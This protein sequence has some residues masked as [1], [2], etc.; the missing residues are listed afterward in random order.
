M[1][2]ENTNTEEVKTESTP[3]E[4]VSSTETAEPQDSYTDMASSSSDKD[5]TQDN[6]FLRTNFYDNRYTT[7][8][9]TTDYLS[10]DQKDK[11]I[12]SPTSLANLSIKADGNI[13]A[14]AGEYSSQKIGAAGSQTEIGIH[15]R[16]V[17]NR[18]E[19]DT[20]EIV[21]NKHKMNPYLYELTDFKKITNPISGIVGDLCIEG[22]VLVKAWDN[23]LKKYV[24]I[25]RRIRTP[26]FFPRLDVPSIPSALDIKDLTSLNTSG[27]NVNGKTLTLDEY[28]AS[29]VGSKNLV[30]TN[31][32]KTEEAKNN[33]VV[34][35]L[36]DQAT[37][38]VEGVV[39]KKNETSK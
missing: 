8:K 39:A 30:K 5:N 10:L 28:R 23:T 13:N 24:L 18:C 19:F 32:Q 3:E 35:G 2:E 27:L 26:M 4:A 12:K 7:I 38:A 17:F 31:A 29:E 1:S 9:N 11:G 33:S 20:N 25:R 16:F 6:A 36:V 14:S 34:S 22:T 37:K 21:I 15:K